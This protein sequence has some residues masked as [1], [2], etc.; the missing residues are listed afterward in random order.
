MPK[1]ADYESV[2]E[3]IRLQIY[4]VLCRSNRRD[5]IISI[6][7]LESLSMV[8]HDRATSILNGQVARPPGEYCNHEILHTWI[9]LRHPDSVKLYYFV[10]VKGICYLYLN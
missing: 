4:F 1:S 6:P 3:R 5:A 8:L 2:N 10:E 7:Y 9:K